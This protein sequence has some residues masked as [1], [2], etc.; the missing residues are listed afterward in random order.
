MQRRAVVHIA[1]CCWFWWMCGGLVCSA[2][3]VCVLAVGLVAAWLAP[4]PWHK[5]L[6]QPCDC[7]RVTVC[8]S[9]TAR[10]T[11]HWACGYSAIAPGRQ[12]N[13][14]RACA[15]RVVTQVLVCCVVAVVATLQGGCA[16]CAAGNIARAVVWLFC[17][18]MV[19][20]SC[21]CDGLDASTCVGS[22][23]L[24]VCSSQLCCDCVCLAVVAL[25][26]ALL[27]VPVSLSCMLS[28]LEG[29]N[30]GRLAPFSIGMHLYCRSAAGVQVGVDEGY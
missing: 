2:D 28:P 1:V 24:Y 19:A 27:L 15:H 4:C 29:A 10:K 6:P 14:G 3:A 11:A 17:A 9:Q 7:G 22:C 8:C 16:R 26:D 23:R 13:Q 25:C 18:F 21:C 5:L 20:A 12:A 30:A